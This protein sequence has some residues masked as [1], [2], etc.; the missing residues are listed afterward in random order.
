MTWIFKWTL[1]LFLL[2]FL[3]WIMKN[4]Y[5]EWYEF[6]GNDTTIELYKL[7]NVDFWLTLIELTCNKWTL[8]DALA[9]DVCNW[10]RIVF[11]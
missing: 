2:T 8:N 1:T 10:L 4:A 9:Y 5:D 3:L 7:S 11:F 6:I